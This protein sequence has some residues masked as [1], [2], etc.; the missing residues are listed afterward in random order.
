MKNS[1]NKIRICVASYLNDHTRINSMYCLIYSLLSQSYQNFE[2]IIHHDG[3]IHDINLKNSIESLSNKITV[4]DNLER[5]GSW[6]HYHRWPTATIN[7][8]AD[9][10]VFTNDDNYY[11]PKFLETMINYALHYNTEFVH[12]DH[13]HNELGYSVL[14]SN[15]EPG[16]IDM[17]AFMSSMNLVKTN[18]WDTYIDIADGLYAKKLASKTTPIK[19]PGVLFIHN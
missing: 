5:K 6:G 10:I 3:P 18:S 16:S 4:L 11:V 9:W 7:N 13:L 12:C 1:N 15:P 8:D 19:V 2:I 17:G 14:V